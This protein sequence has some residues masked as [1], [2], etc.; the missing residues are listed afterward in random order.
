MRT[1]VSAKSKAEGGAATV[2]QDRSA[3]RSRRDEL[4]YLS[5]MIKELGNMADNLGCPTLT[6]ILALARREAQFERD[7]S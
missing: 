3:P 7:R 4:I 2:K 5:D 1:R 6:G